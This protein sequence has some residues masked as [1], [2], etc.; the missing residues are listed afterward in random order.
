MARFAEKLLNLDRRIIFLV[1]FLAVA[2]PILVRFPLPIKPSPLVKAVYDKIEELAQKP[3][4]RV[5]ISFD[6][7]PSAKPELQP[8]ALAILRHCFKRGVKVIGMT[9]WP[10]GQ[11]LAEEA[12]R[13]TAREY[14]R[15]Y[16]E[17]YVFL[18]YKP[19]MGILIL[20]M[21]QDFQLAFER[22]SKGNKLSELPLTKG[23]RSLRDIDYLID[24][25]AGNSIEYW[26][27]WGQEKAKFPMGAGCTAV[28]AP[29]MYPFTNSGNLNGLIGGLAGAAE[30]ES[31]IGRPGKAA[32]GMRPQSVAHGVIV[33]FIL[34]GN[35]LFVW[36]KIRRRS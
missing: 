16:G 27:V 35:L 3:A 17:D 7:D 28:I 29:D 25:A 11:G 1:L 34:L 26:I 5:L 24:L 31:L 21:V 32:D 9:H 2:I 33:T 6:Y 30:Y 20:N 8:M 14:G 22:D 18:G 15:K 12:L 23:L 10:A 36:E 13:T 4:S 19:G